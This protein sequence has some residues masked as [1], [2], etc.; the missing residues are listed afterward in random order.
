MRTNDQVMSN[1]TNKCNELNT[2]MKLWLSG[3]ES[4]LSN[5]M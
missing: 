3:T 1:S 2:Q 4:E 5:Q